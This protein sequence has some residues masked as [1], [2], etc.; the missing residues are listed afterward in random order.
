VAV[1]YKGQEIR[2]SGGTT[3]EAARRKLKKMKAEMAGDEFL[4]GDDTVTVRDLID[5]YET[6]LERR[7]RKSLASVKSHKKPLRRFFGGFAAVEVSALIIERFQQ[8]RLASG[9]S[10]T[11]VDKE[12]EILRA[13]YRLAQKRRLIKQVPFFPFFRAEN[14]RTGFFETDQVERLLRVE[15]MGSVLNPCTISASGR[16]QDPDA[17]EIPPR[18]RSDGIRRNRGDGDRPAVGRKELDFVALGRVAGSVQLHLWES[19]RQ[20]S[21]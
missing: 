4:L 8:R 7:G 13:A 6:D 11:T 3:R 10:M 12:T 2:K 21:T 1:Y 16:R 18:R 20:L 9:R 14:R 19:L 5:S 15:E 17:Q